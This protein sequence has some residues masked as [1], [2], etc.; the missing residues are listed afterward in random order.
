MS[1]HERQIITDLFPLSQKSIDIA[2]EEVLTPG[3]GG[4]S[5]EVA[6]REILRMR[7]NPILFDHIKDMT[8]MYAAEDPNIGSHYFLGCSTMYM[9]FYT[10]AQ[11]RGGI[12]PTISSENIDDHIR[13]ELAD[14]GISERAIVSENYS[15][16]IFS[17]AEAMYEKDQK[18]FQNEDAI[19]DLFK[20][21]RA[22]NIPYS[23]DLRA[24]IMSMYKIFRLRHESEHK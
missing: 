3:G 7:Q 19:N 4:T 6:D 22:L 13:T 16:Q 14:T 11:G 1:S 5:E 15:A 2:V 23:G 17:A 8:Q 18:L 10:E 24:G 12:L 21:I 20:H 9:A